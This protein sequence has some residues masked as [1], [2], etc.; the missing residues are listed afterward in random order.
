MT[1]LASSGTPAQPPYATM[2]AGGV[3]VMLAKVPPNLRLLYGWTMAHGHL[4][5]LRE[6]ALGNGAH[7]RLDMRGFQFG[8]R[9]GVHGHVVQ[10]VADLLGP[11]FPICV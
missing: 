3:L 10:R 7:N 11:G 2:S 4:V 8:A 9:L 6:E 1:T 5:R